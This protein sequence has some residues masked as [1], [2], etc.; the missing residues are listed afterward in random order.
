MSFGPVF[1]FTSSTGS[2]GY[3]E[4][5]Q[6]ELEAVETNV[7]SLFSTNWG[8][9]VMHPL[10]GLNLIEFCFEQINT[11]ELKHRISDRIKDQL[12]RWIPFVQLVDAN[13][14]S[15]EEDSSI[16]ENSFVLKA[17]LRYG[18]STFVVVTTP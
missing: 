8:E 7:K 10:F 11:A 18:N 2:A 13:I 17:K 14:D 1:P 12:G 3:F 15:K 4:G 6:T 5:S 16:D 9:R